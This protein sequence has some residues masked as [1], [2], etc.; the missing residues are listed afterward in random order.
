MPGGAV[1][2]EQGIGSKQIEDTSGNIADEGR[3]QRRGAKWVQ[4]EHL[5]RVAPPRQGDL[6]LEDG[7][8]HT[9]GR[10]ACERREQLLRE[11]LARSADHDVGLTHQ[12]L[13]CQ[14]ELVQR[15]G[16][17]QIN[18]RAERDAERNRKDGDSEATRLLAQL[19]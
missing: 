16:V 2:Q 7:A 13:H 9:H 18:R 4:P 15:G 10:L 17:D 1:A 11:T 3:L 19:G 6:E 12:P 14:A 5:E 8:R